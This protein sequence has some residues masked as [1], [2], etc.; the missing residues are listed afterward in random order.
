MAMHVFS[1]NCSLQT[2]MH[3][4]LTYN[5]TSENREY[6]CMQCLCTG[7]LDLSADSFPL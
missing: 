1:R 2:S 5:V 7:L 6:A 4:R 3:R